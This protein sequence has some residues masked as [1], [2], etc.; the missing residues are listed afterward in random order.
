MGVTA[1]LLEL[2]RLHGWWNKPIFEWKGA[3]NQWCFKLLN[4]LLQTGL[5]W[6]SKDM[7]NNSVLEPLES[8]G[9]KIYLFC[10]YWQKFLLKFWRVHTYTTVSLSVK[11]LRRHAVR[12]IPLE[13]LCLWSCRM[14]RTRCKTTHSLSCVIIQPD[15][16][17]TKLDFCGLFSNCLL[18][19]L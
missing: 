9:S 4:V 18:L 7:R 3:L 17:V 2:S 5:L 14:N 13:Q 10:Y 16:V 19:M 1:E 11:D 15:S 12:L 6:Q 8:M